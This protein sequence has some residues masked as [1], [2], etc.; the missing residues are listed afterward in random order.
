MKLTKQEF[1]QLYYLYNE[2]AWHKS[3]SYSDIINEDFIS[4][5]YSP[6]FDWIFDAA[7]MPEDLFTDLIIWGEY[8]TKWVELENGDL[9]IVEMTNDLDKIYDVYL[10]NEDKNR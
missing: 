5:F 1:K 3:G 2:I 6:L 8:P 4:Q 9:E 7:D 10:N